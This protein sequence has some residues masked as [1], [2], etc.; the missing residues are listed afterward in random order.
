MNTRKPVLVTGAAG[1]IGMHVTIGLLRSGHD[2]VGADN[3]NDYYDVQLKRD[4]L[5]QILNLKDAGKFRFVQLAIENEQQMNELMSAHHFDSIVHLAAQ[6]GVRHSIQDPLAYARSNLV[7]MT[8]VL[9]L[10]RKAGV[11]H[12]VY[13]S[14]SSVYGGCSK[15]PS[16]EAD[17]LDSPASFYAATKTANE[18][19]AASYANL[20]GLPMTGLRFFTVY[21]P[22][23]RPDMAPWMFTKAILEGRMIKLFGHGKPRRDYTYID[24]IAAGVLRVLEMP[25]QPQDS[26]LH[27]V[28]NIGNHQPVSV[29]QF[30]NTLERITGKP[31]RYELLP[32]Q[33]GDVD[34]TCA[35]TSALNKLTGFEPATKLETGLSRFVDW[36]RHYQGGGAQTGFHAGMLTETEGSQE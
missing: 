10:A 11:R 31:A 25:P 13:A 34:V 35:D 8:L 26:H 24:D 9:Q 3:L 22:W 28:L 30:V 1:F 4:R 27:R 20:Y 21:G 14:S 6:A 18:A 29:M 12:M 19:M 2:V 7:G 16:S 5:N 23:G 17:R 33:P 36:Y 32:M 15:V